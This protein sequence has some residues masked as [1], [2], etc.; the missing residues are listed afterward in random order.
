MA[1]SLPPSSSSSPPRSKPPSPLDDMSNAPKDI[2]V[3]SAPKAPGSPLK[4]PT[5]PKPKSD[6]GGTNEDEGKADM[7]TEEVPK[8]PGK[9]LDVSSPEIPKPPRASIGT[10][11]HLDYT[12]ETSKKRKEEIVGDVLPTFRELESQSSRE[13]SPS[14]PKT[15]IKFKIPTTLKHSSNWNR[16]EEEEM[17][18]HYYVKVSVDDPAYSHGREI[19]NRI[20]RH[21]LFG[22]APHLEQELDFTSTTVLLPANWADEDTMHEV[23]TS[24]IQSA[25]KGTGLEM[26]IQQIPIRLIQVHGVLVL[27]GMSREAEVV[28]EKAWESM[29]NVVLTPGDVDW[30]WDTY[31][32]WEHGISSD[33]EPKRIWGNSSAPDYVAKM[34]AAPYAEEYVEMMAW[35]ILN[36]KAR[37]GLNH[38]INDMIVDRCPALKKVLNSR[39]EKYGLGMSHQAL[40]MPTISKPVELKPLEDDTAQEFRN[41]DQPPIPVDKGNKRPLEVPMPSGSDAEPLPAKK[42]KLPPTRSPAL[43]AA[44]NQ[45]RP[46]LNFGR[47]GVDIEQDKPVN[48]GWTPDRAVFN[49]S[50]V[51][52]ST[53]PIAKQKVNPSS[54][55]FK[56]GNATIA[57]PASSQ[58]TQNNTSRDLFNLSNLSRNDSGTWAEGNSSNVLGG[59]RAEESFRVG[60]EPS[61]PSKSNNTPT[62]PFNAFEGQQTTPNPTNSFNSFNTAHTSS[63]VLDHTNMS[64]T[65]NLGGSTSV[66]FNPHSTTTSQSNNAGF[67]FGTPEPMQQNNPTSTPSGF[68]LNHPSF[69]SSTSA[70]SSINAGVSFFGT[71]A[72]PIAPAPTFQ[73]GSNDTGNGENPFMFQGGSSGS[74]STGGRKIKQAKGVRRFPRR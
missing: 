22:L 3:E 27:F 31:G 24:I 21:L 39:Q 43:A 7:N 29:L 12:P 54:G 61:I 32:V 53:V 74:N 34:S 52:K 56:L 13:A 5:S 69:Q 63:Y 64:G 17:H 18:P 2:A 10:K 14:P 42:Q 71:G 57:M 72:N 67:G 40:P 33:S 50:I 11:R 62:P 59:I 58:L 8:T 41:E 35:Q 15:K 4:S 20:P 26:Y 49:Q 44:L 30:I 45:E 68:N 37:G 65:S 16:K 23:I 70:P 28:R 46:S 19:Y 25:K 47:T 55:F 6:S 1:D 60:G 66:H 36:L 48:I 51:G 38:V 73:S 9:G